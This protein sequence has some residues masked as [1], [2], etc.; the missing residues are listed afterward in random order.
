MGQLTN[1]ESF[2]DKPDIYQLLTE[3]EI[4][5]KNKDTLAPIAV[6]H[7]LNKL[8]TFNITIEPNKDLTE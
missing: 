1:K 4:A 2:I 3:L 8:K 5:L 6:E 7:I